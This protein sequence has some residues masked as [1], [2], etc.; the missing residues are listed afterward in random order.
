MSNND[1]FRPRDHAEEVAV[2]RHGVIGSVARCVLSHGALRSALR[3]LS[4]RR[5]CPPGVEGTRTFGYST[6]ERWLYAYRKGGL[7]AL[8]PT[9]RRDRGRARE[10][11]EPQRA[12]LLDVRREHP[13]ATA[14]VILREL[15]A[16]GRIDAG[17]VSEATVRRLYTAH[18]LDRVAARDGA[19]VTTR[20]RWEAERPG[21]LWHGDVCHGATLALGD[22]KV[23]VRIHGM[24][25]DASR[26]VVALEAH[27]TE[28]EVDMIGVL[29]GALR[30]HGPP[31]V[32]Y[33]DNGS[34]YRGDLLRLCCARLG[35]ALVH[36]KPYDPEARGKMERFWRTLRQGCLDHTGALASLDDLNE[37]LAAFLSEHYHVS[38]HAS[39]LGHSPGRVWCERPRT[40]DR[41]DEAKLRDALTARAKRLVRKD[42]T[43]SVGNRDWELDQGF[44]AGRKVVV[45][46][47]MVDATEA[48]WVEHE[49]HRYPLR[50][51]DPKANA[52]RQRPPRRA[53]TAAPARA[54]VPFDPSATLVERARARAAQRETARED[55]G[56]DE[57]TEDLFDQALLDDE[58]GA[59]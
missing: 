7:A 29:V 40:V 43:L 20:L 34:T 46:R 32:I 48:P 57:L 18:G 6:L 55:D 27:A 47:C 51:V 33:L 8:R 56:S 24:L 5:F 44:L 16:S 38:A 49:G 19:G 12:L 14:S 50:L 3:E 26:Y 11:T 39:L 2:F 9:P 58:G 35:I 10:L 37:R 17:A 42:N 25:D 31:E 13:A 15:V 1:E 41:L 21:V 53:H 45:A 4:E 36:A 54:Q 30:R 28:R 59:R 23:P 22:R 52:T